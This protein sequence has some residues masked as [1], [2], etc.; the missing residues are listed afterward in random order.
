MSMLKVEEINKL[1]IDQPQS[2]RVVLL[3][4]LFDKL[5]AKGLGQQSVI[6]HIASLH[7]RYDRQVFDALGKSQLR[8]EV[9]LSP[10]E[11]SKKI[12][13]YRKALE[14]KLLKEIKNNT[15]ISECKKIKMSVSNSRYR[16][17][18]IEILEN[19]DQVL[20]FS[21]SLGHGKITKIYK[22]KLKCGKLVIIKQYKSSSFFY[23][24]SRSFVESRAMISWRAAHLFK[25]FGIPTAVPLGMS[26]ERHGP[27]LNASYYISEF[28][29]GQ[30]MAD[31]YE[32]GQPQELWE[33]V[34]EQIEDILVTFPKVFMTHGDFKATNFII[35]NNHPV[36]IDL[37]SV[38]LYR[39]KHLFK[40]SYSRHID[41]FEQ[42]W[43][44]RPTAEKHFKP[45]I[46][47]I[48]TTIP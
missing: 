8:S 10:G 1:L 18:V 32:E 31:F 28:I 33:T 38:T 17:E 48:R 24:L 2:E 11:L 37:D 46:A 23:R 45:F 44:V 7:P 29:D 20:S 39:N 35:K 4:N 42:N 19:I 15:L 25:L 14:R 16:S 9:S 47:R 13:S 5:K 34:S 40:S 30:I 26:E 36:L 3:T 21:Q 43:K 22:H 6:D 41:R 12:F 27:F